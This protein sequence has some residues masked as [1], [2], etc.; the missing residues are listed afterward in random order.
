M[1]LGAPT[2][3]LVA[4]ALGGAAP[5][6]RAI[7][8][9]V[10]AAAAVFALG[11]HTPVYETAVALVPPLRVLRYPSKAIV[12]VALAWALLA[13]V[14]FDRWRAPEALSRRRWLWIV[15]GPLLAVTTAGAALAVLLR[16]R[17]GLFGPF[18]LPES[19]LSSTWAEALAP[20]SLRI[21]CTAALGAAVV[22]AAVMRSRRP[23]AAKPLAGVVAGL[24]I[25]DLALAGMR[26]NPTVPVDFY[27]LRPPILDAVRQDDLSRL[28]VY[29]YPFLAAASGGPDDPYR[30]ARY[31]PE[32]SF[33]AGRTL[34]ARLY[35]TPPVGGCWGLFG[36]YEPDLIGLYPAPLATLVR[37]MEQAEG[38]PAYARFLRL[39]AVKH[40]SA[41]RRH[42]GFE[43]LTPWARTPACWRG[44]SCCSRSRTPCRARMRWAPRGRATARRPGSS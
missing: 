44:P 25:L 19:A 33:D 27:K 35:L 37:W 21:A 10:L 2:L 12:L 13:G 40:V 14:G 16:W 31:P 17:P 8:L 41:L 9:A 6:A 11:R 3:A 24:A 36:S 38:T 22:V 28:F 5:R 23:Q 39:G 1:Y 20:A 18:L 7:A 42:G 26:L 29:R 30:I 34:A 4:A 43:T 15:V 32:M